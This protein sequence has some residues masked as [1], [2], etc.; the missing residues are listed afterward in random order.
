[1]VRAAAGLWQR[2][3]S[4]YEILERGLVEMAAQQCRIEE[5][6]RKACRETG[7]HEPHKEISWICRNCGDRVS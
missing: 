7:G 6:R 3:D 5:E 2:T 1:V 4:G